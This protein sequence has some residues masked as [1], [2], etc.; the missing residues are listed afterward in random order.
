MQHRRAPLIRHTVSLA[1]TCPKCHGRKCKDCDGKGYIT[2]AKR[3]DPVRSKSLKRGYDARNLILLFALIL[4]CCATG[5]DP[6][7]YSELVPGTTTRDEAIIMLGEPTSV[8]AVRGGTLLQWINVY[9]LQPIHVAILF[10]P[11]GRM[12]NTQLVT[13]P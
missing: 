13:K 9:S 1:K 6:H 10:G 11:D 7:R 8:A 12:V 2:L 5:P 3:S 4:A